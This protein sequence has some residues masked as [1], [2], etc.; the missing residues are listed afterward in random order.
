M[1]GMWAW[2]KARTGVWPQPGKGNPWVFK[3]VWF[4][5]PPQGAFLFLF[6]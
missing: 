2:G 5:Y 3:G 6:H 4:N 1:W